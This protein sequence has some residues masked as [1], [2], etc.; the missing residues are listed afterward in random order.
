MDK[1][2]DMMAGWNPFGQGLFF[3]IVLFA[4]QVF[5]KQLAY[6]GLVLFRGWPPKG[7]PSIA[8]LTEEEEKKKE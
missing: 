2:L 5:F 3:L 4:F 6:L 8:A 1:I 7:T